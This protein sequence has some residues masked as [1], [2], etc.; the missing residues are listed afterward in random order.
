MYFLCGKGDLLN[1]IKASILRWEVILDYPD[2]PNETTRVMRRR[3]SYKIR[4]REKT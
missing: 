2:K 4:E 3:W 1:V